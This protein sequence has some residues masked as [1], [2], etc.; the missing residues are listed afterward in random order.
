[1]TQ[2]V[3]TKNR[4]AGMQVERDALPKSPQE[5][6]ERLKHSLEV[7]SEDKCQVVWL[8]VPIDQ[9]DLIPVAAQEGFEFHH[10]EVSTLFL[11]KALRPDAF[12]YPYASHSL[13]VGAVVLS[14]E[15]KV[16]VVLE[17]Y[18]AESRPGYYKLPGGLVNHGENIVDAA[19]REVHE[20]TGID[21][22]FE[23]LACFKHHHRGKFDNSNI[24]FVCRMKALTTEITIA[25]IEIADAKWM[26]IDEYLDLPN[27]AEFNKSAVEVAVKYQPMKVGT[28]GTE[29]PATYE[30][31]LP[32][33]YVDCRQ[34]LHS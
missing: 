24:Y 16:L 8:P 19:K 20:E 11:V 12:V 2:L 25:P 28:I 32:S 9:S 23:S 6:G 27:A 34:G 30:A 22:C 18:H 26:H 1:M 21:A 4:F 10:T 14:P 3:A 31:L 29:N 15:Q 7:W 13:G 5:F 17:E 33:E